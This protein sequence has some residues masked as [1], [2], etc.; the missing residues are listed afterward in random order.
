[1]PTRRLHGQQQQ[2]KRLKI[3]N[4]PDSFI[5]NIISWSR[6]FQ[7]ASSGSTVSVACLDQSVGERIFK[8]EDRSS[9]AT[10]ARAAASQLWSYKSFPSPYLIHIRSSRPGHSGARYAARYLLHPSPLLYS[11][12]YGYLPCP[13]LPCLALPNS[14]GAAF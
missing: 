7:Q 2:R 5:C 13:A 14:D 4:F 6:R 1:M 3:D 11:N 10:A 8:L 12:Q 9:C